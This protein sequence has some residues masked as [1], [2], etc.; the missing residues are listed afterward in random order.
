MKCQGVVG[1]EASGS[2]RFND[3]EMRSAQ[4]GVLLPGPH[5]PLS[6]S[7]NA[8]LNSTSQSLA[9]ASGSLPLVAYR[10]FALGISTGSRER[11]S[12]TYPWSVRAESMERGMW[13][14]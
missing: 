3:R 7:E 9:L 13:S 2:G 11:A 10:Q 6:N 12:G 5:S 8:S 1:H 4:R 14:V